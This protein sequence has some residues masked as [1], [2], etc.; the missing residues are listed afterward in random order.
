ME[1]DLTPQRQAYLDARGHTILTAC[2]GSGKTTS[3]VKKL[4]AVSQYCAERYGKHTGFA[5]LSFTNKACAELKQKYRE[6]HDERLTFPNEVLTID[7]FIMQYVVLPFWYLCDACKKKPIVVNEEEILNPIYFNNVFRNGKWNSYPIQPLSKFGKKQYDKVLYKKSPALVSREK[8]GYR[9]N[10]NTINK[11]KEVEYCETVFTYRLSKGFITSGDALWMACDILKNHQE[12]ARALVARFPYIIV[13]EAQDNSEL[14][15]DFFKLL[16]RSGLQNLEFV[17]D[18]CQS[19]YGFNNAKPEL[20]QSMMEERDWNVLP[21]SEC[22]RS[23]QRIIDLYSKLKSNNVSAITSHGVEDKEIPIVV[24]KYDDGNVKD[25]IRAFYQVCEDNNLLSRIILARGVDK[26][27]KLSGV[28][29]VNF[30]YWKTDL[31][32][33]LID[34]VFASEANDMDYAFRKIRLV[35]SRLMTEDSPD[36]KRQFIHEIEHN[37]D[38]NARI[39]GFLKQIPSFS[40]SF[41]EWS[42][43]T[44]V[45][46]HDFWELDEQPMFVPYQRQVGYKMKEM[47]NVPVERFHQSRDESSDYHKNIDT[48]HAVKGATLDAVLLFLSSNS[49]GQGISLND[50]PRRAIR[51]MTESQRMIYVACSRATQFLA[52]AV[53]KS[54]ADE[55]IRRTLAGV[56]IDIRYINLQG[57]LDFTD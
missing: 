21:L 35:L 48:I 36:A 47:G 28:K 49:K 42:E 54:I 15:F 1:Y 16:K 30:K 33:L 55:T 56:N 25:I 13:D 10:H 39:F 40:L 38:W 3:I 53:P 12:I 26:C 34:A 7:S 19:I 11:A 4:R 52:F 27:K 29:D 32:Y 8:N 41:K 23:N 5:C 44:C 17:G 22:R 50:F 51:N 57:E 31:P 45:L 14:H 43:Q 46:L 6:M 37:I 9:W 18:I 2:P 24:Y 20:L